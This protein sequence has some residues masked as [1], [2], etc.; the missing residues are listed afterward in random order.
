MAVFRK[1]GAS[2]FDQEKADMLM[3]DWLNQEEYEYVDG[4]AR[5]KQP[6]KDAKNEHTMATEKAVNRRKSKR[7]AASS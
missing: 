7:A 6:K 5:R 1:L 3:A 4:A 2:G